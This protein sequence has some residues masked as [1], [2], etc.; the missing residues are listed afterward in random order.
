MSEGE[1]L[2]ERYIDF[3]KEKL[4]E[5]SLTKEEMLRQGFNIFSPGR[6]MAEPQNGMNIRVKLRN[7]IS[8]L[9]ECFCVNI[10]LFSYDAN[11]MKVLKEKVISRK[12]VP[13]SVSFIRQHVHCLPIYFSCGKHGKKKVD[14]GLASSECSLHCYIIK[15][16][17]KLLHRYKCVYCDRFFFKKS[18]CARHMSQGSC[19]IPF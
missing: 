11:S 7:A 4:G 8:L 15:D 2:V 16:I 19:L 1:S 12:G 5:D 3:M 18:H 9:E 14:L 13:P 6:S 17:A 10:N